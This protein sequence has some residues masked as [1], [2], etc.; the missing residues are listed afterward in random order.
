MLKKVFAE[1]V[2]ICIGSNRYSIDFVRKPK[3]LGQRPVVISGE[4]GIVC[5]LGIMIKIW[6]QKLF[7]GWLDGAHLTSCVNQKLH[8]TRFVSTKEMTLGQGV[9]GNSSQVYCFASAFPDGAP[10]C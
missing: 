10:L 4:W 5:S 1:Y 9:A 7:A 3:I 6:L 8:F 2:M